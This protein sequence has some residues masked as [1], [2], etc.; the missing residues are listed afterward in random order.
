MSTEIYHTPEGFHRSE[1][2]QDI[3]QL[4]QYRGLDVRC[5][6]IDITLYHGAHVTV[7]QAERFINYAKT[8]NAD[9][10]GVEGITNKKEVGGMDV[11]AA[12]ASYDFSSAIF[13]SSTESKSMPRFSF[14]ID[15]SDPLSRD[16]TMPQIENFLSDDYAAELLK[17]VTDFDSFKRLL[18]YR[19]VGLQSV[20]QNRRE[21]AILEKF[22]ET[23]AN[24]LMDNPDLLKKEKLNIIIFF[25]AAHT[26][27]YSKIAGYHSPESTRQVYSEITRLPDA[28]IEKYGQYIDFLLKYIGIKEG[29]TV[30]FGTDIPASSYIPTEDEW[31]FIT[32]SLNPAF[33]EKLGE[34]LKSD[35]FISAGVYIKECI[36][37]FDKNGDTSDQVLLRWFN[38]FKKGG[39]LGITD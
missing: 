33:E 7:E 12:K 6:H 24:C 14:D 32:L 36:D 18:I 20:L 39:F 9:I 1:F 23:A 17:K 22:P 19:Y 4:L 38:A 27:L 2:E 15:V 35:E 28:V 11:L 21:N 16:Y 5:P 13:E 37:S 31:R 30:D 26:G 25:G 3:S 34:R 8:H 10:V 29:V